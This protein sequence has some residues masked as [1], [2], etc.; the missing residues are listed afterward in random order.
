MAVNGNLKKR[1]QTQ[2]MI[3]LA[4][5]IVI[6]VLVAVSTTAAW[7]IRTKSDSA[8][9]I[10]ANPVN[11]SIAEF[12]ENG[13]YKV[14]TN[15]LEPYN[16][17]IYP[18]DNIKLNLG[19]QMGLDGEQSSAAYVRVKLTIGLS[20][21]SD[22]PDEDYIELEPSPS[23]GTGTIEGAEGEYGNFKDDGDLLIEYVNRP[24]DNNWELIDFNRFNQ[25]KVDYTP[26][27][28]YV[29]KT[30]NA[31]NEEVARI[32]SAQEQIEFLKGWI[33]LSKDN[34]TN[35]YANKKFT[36]NYIVEAIQTANVPD[37][38]KDQGY[39]PWWNFY[40]GDIEDIQNN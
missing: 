36:I 19:M 14:V 8:D 30:V 6:I 27:Y 12:D 4:L 18:G 1:I 28:W 26:D 40:K 16:N 17:R 33:K 23:G 13:K 32:A 20:S 22:N 31:K 25:D 3:I 37:P 24:N 35:K 10:L 15:I 2:N 29:Y 21:V 38:I 39:G 34:I 7:Y 5:A 9:L 11:I